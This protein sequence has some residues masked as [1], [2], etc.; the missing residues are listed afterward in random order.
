MRKHQS[1]V[2]LVELLTV[3]VIIGVLSAI[4]IPSYRNYVL[5]ANRADAK[6]Q[7]LATA[8]QLERCFTQFNSYLAAAG[9]TVALPV[10]SGNGHYQIAAAGGAL[11]ATAFTLTAT[12]QAGQVTDA[13]CGTLTLTDVGIRGRSGTG[14]LED[15]WGK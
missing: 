4:V 3:M 2:T 15:C 6:A 7:L 13:A 12:P 10:P 1:G 5:R 9:C 11:T 8:G 14:S